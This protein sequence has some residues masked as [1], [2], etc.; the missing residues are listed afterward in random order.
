MYFF[1]FL[2][3]KI[4]YLLY[5]YLPPHPAASIIWP[6]ILFATPY[7]IYRFVLRL[8]ARHSTALIALVLLLSS[9][10]FLSLIAGNFTPGKP[11]T[12]F[13]LAVALNI[14]LAIQERSRSGQ[15]LC[16]APKK[17]MLPLLFVIFAGFLFDE[18]AYLMY[19][20]LPIMFTRLFI[21]WD[22][23]LWDWRMAAPKV[24]FNTAVFAVPG[25]LFL[26]FS[27]WLLPLITSRLEHY[28]TDVLGPLHGTSL[29]SNFTFYHLFRNFMSLLGTSLAPRQVSPLL[30]EPPFNAIFDQE[31]T[32][33]K[34]AIFLAVGVVCSVILWEG[35]DNAPPLLSRLGLAFVVFLLWQTLLQ[36][37]H[38]P[39]IDG[40]IYGSL[41]TLFFS[42]GFALILAVGLRLEGWPRVAGVVMLVFVVATQIDNFCAI[43]RSQVDWRNSPEFLQAD[44]KRDVPGFKFSVDQK[45]KFSFGEALSLW[46]C[47][48][49]KDWPCDVFA[50][51]VSPGALYLLAEFYAVDQAL[52][53]HPQK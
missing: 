10:D 52:S 47:W 41:Y 20:V 40:Y 2:D 53:L 22:A 30:T 11:M 9:V 15:Y 39:V 37:F 50:R 26:A 16:D 13:L 4:R 1:L 21:D 12:L 49:H 25:A 46:R 24:A 33:A 36:S 3:Q 51:Q 7:L 18:T 29:F 6:F 35:R 32:F 28:A 17:L 5:F 19:P 43:N 14:A 42:I 38:V 44:L 45:A 34:V 48:R 23:V 31:I 8:T 27:F